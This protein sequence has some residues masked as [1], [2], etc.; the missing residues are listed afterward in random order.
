MPSKCE[1]Y[2][3]CTVEQLE[4][5]VNIPSGSRHQ[6]KR[7]LVS[8]RTCNCLLQYRE[9][10]SS[11]GRANH[12]GWCDYRAIIH[13]P[14]SATWRNGVPTSYCQRRLHHVRHQVCNEFV[15]G[16]HNFG[17]QVASREGNLVYIFCSNH[18]FVRATCR[19]YTAHYRQ[20]QTN[21]SGRLQG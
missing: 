8:I 13:R 2:C 10:E 6:H 1:P 21:M 9:R 17:S 16:I 3:C 18:C 4:A 19:C 14:C 15:W 5:M 20:Q 7:T 12:D 11:T